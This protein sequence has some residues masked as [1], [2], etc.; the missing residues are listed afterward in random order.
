MTSVCPP[1]SA[2]IIQDSGA[3]SDS[4]E[5]RLSFKEALVRQIAHSYRYGYYKQVVYRA[6]YDLLID[7]VWTNGNRH[8]RRWSVREATG[9]VTETIEAAKWLK[10]NYRSP[11]ILSAQGVDATQYAEC[12]SEILPQLTDHDMFGLG[13]WCIIGKMPKRMMTCFDE[14]IIKVIPMVAQYTKRVHIWGVIYAPALGHLLWLCDQFGIALSTDSVGPSVRP[15][16]G[17]WGYMGWK[18]KSYLRKDGH[19]RGHD[20]IAHVAA[21]RLWLDKFRDTEFYREPIPKPKQLY[22]F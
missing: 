10:K 6:S 1:I 18:D 12:A 16:F 9:A 14:S 17:V 13:G 15:C 8:K 21:T 7:E 22:L 20:R 3:F 5:E 11:V 4:P 2:K 19:A